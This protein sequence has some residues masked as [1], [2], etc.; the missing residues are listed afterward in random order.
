MKRR[1][2]S[3][4]GEKRSGEESWERGVE[5]KR[6]DDGAWAGEGGEE[7]M[8]ARWQMFNRRGREGSEGGGKPGEK[9][10]WVGG[11]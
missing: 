6:G 2:G 7:G 8:K 5:G 11:R 3:I 1:W 10:L 9:L 4:G